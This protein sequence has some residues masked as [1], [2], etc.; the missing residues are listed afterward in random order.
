MPVIGYHRHI[1]IVDASPAD[2]EAFGRMLVRDSNYSYT[3]VETDSAHDALQ[4]CLTERP[5]CI[6]LGVNLPDQGGVSFLQDFKRDYKEAYI[7][8]VMLSEPGDEGAAV[9]AVKLGAQDYLVKGETTTEEL[10]VTVNNAMD[11]VALGKKLA[12]KQEELEE[13]AATAAKDLEGPLRRVVGYTE[14]LEQEAAG[15]LGDRGM[16]CLG[17]IAIHAKAMGHLVGELLAYTTT[18]NAHGRPPERVDLETLTRHVLSCLNDEIEATGAVIEIGEMVSIT[19]DRTE[20]VQLVTHL[21]SN[22][23]KFHKPEQPAKVE[24]QSLYDGDYMHLTIKDNGIGIDREDRERIFTPLK[25]LHRDRGYKGNGIGLAKCR[26]IVEQYGGQIWVRSAL[27]EG[28]IFH[29]A[30][31]QSTIQTTVPIA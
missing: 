30:L 5:D 14:I 10:L 8:I 15:K 21:I 19:A 27:G 7:P 25:R 3:I 22:A 9:E 17:L 18:L 29:V 12:L 6:L 20:M 11:R 1:L 13:F 24:I 4:L 28:A 31:P 2:R 16:E 23:V 26:R